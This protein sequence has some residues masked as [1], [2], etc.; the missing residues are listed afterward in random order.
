LVGVGDE[1]TVVARIAAQ[2][3]VAVEESDGGAYRS[4]SSFVSAVRFVPSVFTM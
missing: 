1:R 2:V 3:A 4:T